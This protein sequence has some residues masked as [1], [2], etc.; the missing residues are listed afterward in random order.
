M[1]SK[2]KMTLSVFTVVCMAP[3]LN[4]RMKMD[5]KLYLHFHPQSMI[6]NKIVNKTEIANLVS[7][8]RT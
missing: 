5:Q 3:L 7:I 4:A 2:K 6:M 8:D 1:S